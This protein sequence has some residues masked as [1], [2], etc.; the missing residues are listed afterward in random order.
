MRENTKPTSQRRPSDSESE[1]CSAPARKKT[2]NSK[3]SGSQQPRIDVCNSPLPSSSQPT[4]QPVQDESTMQQ[5]VTSGRRA[6][7]FRGRRGRGAGI[8]SSSSS[9]TRA[10]SPLPSPPLL[11]QRSPLPNST[12]PASP[13]SPAAGPCTPPSERR[14]ELRSSLKPS[15]SSP[16]TQVSSSPP[17]APIPSPPLLQA[18][19]PALPSVS[20]QPPPRPS[21]SRAVLDEQAGSTVVRAVSVA[22]ELANTAFSITTANPS[23]CEK[24]SQA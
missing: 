16:P 3:N 18:S 5:P 1:P 8:L 13:S 20:P 22:K 12:P 7:V 23:P 2:K 6:A 21:L 15:S 17:P 10:A 11:R 4:P 14:L 19:L 9:R 24:K